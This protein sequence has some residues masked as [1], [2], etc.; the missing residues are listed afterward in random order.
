VTLIKP[1]NTGNWKRKYWMTISVENA[2]EG[3]MDM[4]HRLCYDDN[5]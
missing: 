1:K 5:N 2:M 4:Q 3:A